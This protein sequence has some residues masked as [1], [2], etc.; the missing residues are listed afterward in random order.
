MARILIVEDE[1]NLRFSI[2]QTLMRAGH[3]VV[4]AS[5][6]THAWE[7]TRKHDFDALITDVNLGS[8]NGIDQIGR[9]SCRERV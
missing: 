6:A 7:T 8:E 9:A 5:S 1:E 4:E 2:R 3:D